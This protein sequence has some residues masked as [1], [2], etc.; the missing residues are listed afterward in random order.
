MS[1]GPRLRPLAERFWP[2]VRQGDADACWPWLA[3]V[4]SQGYGRIY[5]QDLGGPALAHRV[6]WGLA[7][8]VDPG[9]RLICHTCDN[10]PCCNPKHLYAG[11]SA[12]NNGDTVARGRARRA[13]GERSGKAKLSA[14]QLDEIRMLAA[15]GVPQTQIAAAMGVSSSHVSRILS[16]KRRVYGC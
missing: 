7:N 5:V 8:G 14:E 9:D 15:T 1:R 6:A 16:R 12:D 3:G 10:P 2:K 11:T 4:T 13:Y